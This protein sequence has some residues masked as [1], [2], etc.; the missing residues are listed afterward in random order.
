MPS[1]GPHDTLPIFTN[2]TTDPLEVA[3]AAASYAVR[4]TDGKAGVVIFTDT[5]YEIADRQVERAW[6]R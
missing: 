6:P 3:Q 2:I 4:R 5:I 1:P